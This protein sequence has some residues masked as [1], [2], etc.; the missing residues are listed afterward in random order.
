MATHDVG[1]EDTPSIFEPELPPPP[2]TTEPTV[3]NEDALRVT[4]NPATGASAPLHREALSKLS[5]WQ[6]SHEQHDDAAPS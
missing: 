1:T 4:T 5:G 2:H 6:P 3:D